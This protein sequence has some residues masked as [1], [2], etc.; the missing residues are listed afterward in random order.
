MPDT[1]HAHEG[2][3]S[4]SALYTAGTWS[5]ARLP[6]AELVTPKQARTVFRLTNLVL[7]L[8]RLFRP[9]LPSLRHSLVHRHLLLDR[10]LAEEKPV[11][12]V[13][14]A[15]GLSR[16]GVTVSADPGVRYLEIDLPRMVAR[17]R[18]LLEATDAGRAVLARPGYTLMDGDATGE[19]WAAFVDPALPVVVVVE[20][21][22][23]YLDDAARRLLWTRVARVLRHSGGA[24]LFDL[25]PGAEEPPPGILGRGLAWLMERFTRGRGFVRDKATRQML[26]EALHDA[27]FGEVEVVD[28][29][30]VAGPLGLPYAD[31]RT[32]AVLFR[33]RLGDA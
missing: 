28:A 24:L 7:G 4:V 6:G 23:V 14:L 19:G 32:Q 29:A 16:R 13:E 27:G 1:E 12:V 21:L 18:E 5:W 22:L 3:L 20:G 2:D 8:V 31:K 10:M 26:V 9:R 33:C 25:T 30:T 11:Q 17:K 15:C